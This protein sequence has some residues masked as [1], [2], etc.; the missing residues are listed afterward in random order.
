MVPGT[1]HSAETRAKMSAAHTGRRR[2]A[3]QRAAMTGWQHSDETRAAMSAR[4]NRRSPEALEKLRLAVLGKPKSPEHREK[5]SL[6]ARRRTGERNP[7]WK[8]G[9]T[10]KSRI[11]RTSREQVQWAADVKERD[12][13]TCQDCG[14]R[15][16]NM[17]AHHLR[18]FRDHPDLRTVLTNGVTLCIPCHRGRHKAVPGG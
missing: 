9:V 7:S 2:S 17:H 15:G 1:K 6:A 10:P 12:N 4:S 13:W 5:L 18:S 16:G 14:K 8:G 11:A 3:E